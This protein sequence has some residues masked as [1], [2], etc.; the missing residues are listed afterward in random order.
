MKSIN[1]A[2]TAGTQQARAINWKNT[3]DHRCA[4]RLRCKG[5]R[6]AESCIPFI[7]FVTAM[8]VEGIVD[9]GNITGRSW[10]AKPVKA[11]ERAPNP[12]PHPM[13]I[14]NMNDF[15]WFSSGF[16]AETLPLRPYHTRAPCLKT[17]SG[18]AAGCEL[19]RKL[20]T[21]MCRKLMGISCPNCL[22]IA[23][24]AGIVFAIFCYYTWHPPGAIN[25]TPLIP[26]GLR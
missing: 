11:G 14:P 1:I 5:R 18:K 13:M 19:S 20:F 25:K 4:R 12:D 15:L 8:F 17:V 9:L 24:F 3:T 7:R 2:G 10:R 26:C 6:A 16:Q 22:L 23:C 21:C